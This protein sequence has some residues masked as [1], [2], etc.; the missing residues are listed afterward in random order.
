MFIGNEPTDGSSRTANTLYGG[1]VYYQTTGTWTIVTGDG[2]GIF[3]AN[4]ERAEAPRL[5]AA[6]YRGTAGSAANQGW[7]GYYWS[8][9]ATSTSGS[10]YFLSMGNTSV[11]A[12]GGSGYAYGLAV[13]CVRNPE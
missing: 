6:G 4:T 10:G 1:K 7:V 11:G 3:P 13:R 12:S 5:P 2:V 8:S 9:S